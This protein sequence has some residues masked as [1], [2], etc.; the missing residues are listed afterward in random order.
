MEKKNLIWKQM[1]NAIFFIL[2]FQFS[3]YCS[4]EE[5]KLNMVDFRNYFYDFSELSLFH[6]MVELIN[7][8]NTI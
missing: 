2:D 8:Y 5:N 7:I 6:L 1:L 3:L 4:Q